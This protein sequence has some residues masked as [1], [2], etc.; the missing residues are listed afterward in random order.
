MNPEAPYQQPAQGPTPGTPPSPNLPPAGFPNPQPSAPT[1]PTPQYTSASQ[2]D[3]KHHPWGLIIA[4]VVFIIGFLSSS[5][6]A[7]WAYAEAQDYKNNVDEK[8]AAAVSEAVAQTEET[9]EK[10]FAERSKSPH[11]VYKGPATFGAMEITYPKTWAAMVD[12]G[13]SSSPVNGYFHPDYVPGPRSETAFALRVEVVERSY[14]QMLGSYDAQAKRGEVK[15]A[16][17]KAKRVPS[18]L[19]ARLDGEIVRGFQGSAVLLPLRDKTIRISTLS[20]G[21]FGNDFNKVIL[22]RFIFTP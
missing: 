13:T 22:E 3:K 4:L 17:F 8:V 21:S 5:G 12:E 18:V 9:K 20:R 11:K 6:F 7:F 19:G 10:E 1:G 14:D 16:P 2:Q 15:V